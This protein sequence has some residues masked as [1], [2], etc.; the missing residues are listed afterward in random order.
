MP[1]DINVVTYNN[2]TIYSLNNLVR[3]GFKSNGMVNLNLS[4][5]L[6]NRNNII[7]ECDINDVD[8]YI[9]ADI[10]IIGLLCSCYMINNQK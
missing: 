2:N 1:Y 7:S 8:K 4:A 6:K 10:N 3:I 9:N 5:P